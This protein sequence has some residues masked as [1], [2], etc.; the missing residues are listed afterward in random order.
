MSENK[1]GGGRTGRVG[2]K[3]KSHGDRNVCVPLKL[4]FVML[5]HVLLVDRWISHDEG[6]CVSVCVGPWAYP[7]RTNL[8][9]PRPLYESG[10]R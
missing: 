9:S 5:L 4:N 6:V 3:D 10:G 2:G 1:N 7:T 8:P